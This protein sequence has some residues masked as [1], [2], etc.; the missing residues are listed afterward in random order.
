[1][2]ELT[3]IFVLYIIVLRKT[4]PSMQ[5]LLPQDKQL[6]SAISQELKVIIGCL[7]LSIVSLNPLALVFFLSAICSCL[8]VYQFL[9]SFKY[10]YM[11]H[12]NIETAYYNIIDLDTIL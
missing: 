5:S 8:K 2:S 10:R 1:M 9:Q 4:Y 6:S 3:D 11:Y 12:Q 7:V